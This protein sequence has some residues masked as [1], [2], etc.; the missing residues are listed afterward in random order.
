M[1]QIWRPEQVYP[2]I[3]HVADGSILSGWKFIMIGK[4]N[5]VVWK[6]ALICRYSWET[7]AIPRCIWMWLECIRMHSLMKENRSRETSEF[8]W[9]R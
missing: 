2:K 8:V 5:R 1:L 4:E 3:I 7:Y 6:Q 9:L